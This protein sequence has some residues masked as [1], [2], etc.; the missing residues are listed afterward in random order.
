MNKRLPSRV[1]TLPS[2][3]KENKEISEWRIII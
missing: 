2:N 3:G 1:K